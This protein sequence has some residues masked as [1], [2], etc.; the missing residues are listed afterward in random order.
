MSEQKTTLPATVNESDLLTLSSRHLIAVAFFKSTSKTYGL[1]VSFAKQAELYGEKILGRRTQHFAVF[2][3]SRAQAAAALAFM[4]QGGY[5]KGTLLFADGQLLSYVNRHSII[6]TI[7]CYVK[8]GAT[9]DPKS[10]CVTPY[11]NYE[12]NRTHLVP[13]R[14]IHGKTI[15]GSPYGLEDIDDVLDVQDYLLGVAAHRGCQWC[16]NFNPENHQRLGKTPS[17]K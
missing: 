10:Y 11:K 12:S 3:R 1:A 5:W 13:C 15:D 2:G 9:R 4:E 6:E 16:P 8:S 14:L 7:R 17:A